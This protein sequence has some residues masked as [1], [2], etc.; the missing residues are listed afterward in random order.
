[1]ST[2]GVNVCLREFLDRGNGA[3]GLVDIDAGIAIA[4][5]FSSGQIPVYGVES[6]QLVGIPRRVTIGS[7]NER[8]ITQSLL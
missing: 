4:N 1:M 8:H 7:L 5:W 6:E 2:P 3:V